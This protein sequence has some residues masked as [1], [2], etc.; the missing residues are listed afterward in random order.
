MFVIFSE[1]YKQIYLDKITLSWSLIASA[2]LSMHIGMVVEGSYLVVPKYLY[3]K[4]EEIE[5][6]LK[7]WLG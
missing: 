4:I 5:F 3:V 2:S 1:V 6:E 7:A